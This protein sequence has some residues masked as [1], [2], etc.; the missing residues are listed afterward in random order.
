[1]LM[2]C[3]LAMVHLHMTI[4]ELSNPN[5]IVIDLK[6][7]SVAAGVKNVVEASNDML[8]RVRVAQYQTSPKVARAVID[9]HSKVPYSVTPKG[10]E[11]LIQI[12]ESKVATA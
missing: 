1:M 3:W 9:L 2:L 5:R 11:L 7:V 6:S 8:S 12:G 10:R 4:F